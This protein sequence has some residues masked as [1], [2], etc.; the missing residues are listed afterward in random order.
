MLGKGVTLGDCLV[1]IAFVLPVALLAGAGLG[2][3]GDDFGLSGG[4][5][6][7][8]I[9]ALSAISGQIARMVIKRRAAARSVRKDWT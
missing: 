3:F 7:V 1:A 2:Y 4:Q 8:A 5:R 6:A 9:A